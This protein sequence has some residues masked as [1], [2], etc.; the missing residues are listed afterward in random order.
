MIDANTSSLGQFSVQNIGRRIN[1]T[2]DDE[3]NCLFTPEIPNLVFLNMDN[4]KM[5]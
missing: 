2:T 5:N 1:V 3:V 4:P